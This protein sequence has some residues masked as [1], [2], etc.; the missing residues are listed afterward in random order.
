MKRWAL[1]QGDALALLREL[2]ER[3]VDAIVTDPPYSSGGMYRGDRSELPRQKYIGTDVTLERPD[4]AG[5]NRDGRAW[6]YWSA[7]WI[8]ECLR[9][10]VPGAV[11][12]MFC[13]WRQLA[14]ATDALQCGGFVLRGIV[15]WDKTEAAR[16][17][18]GR[19]RQ[20]AEFIVWGS[21]GPM[22]DEERAASIGVLPGCIRCAKNH[23]DDLVHPAGK[24]VPVMQ[25]L[26][27]A[28]PVGGLVLD[29]FSGYAPVGVAALLERRRFLGFELQVEWIA[30]AR[31]R[32]EAVA[33][34]STPG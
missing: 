10:A 7:L 25:E 3:S 23:D 19:F 22:V 1:H 24:P 34:D 5:D 9:V 16:P 26:V 28:A 29:P 18:L 13:D 2:P 17:Q 6:L 33:S 14:T 15:P 31:E 20:Q 32:L 12:C 8:G 27:R 21:A 11:L 4:F 30:L